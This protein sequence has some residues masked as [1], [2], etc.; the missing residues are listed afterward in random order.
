MAQSKQFNLSSLD[1]QK[2]FK[3]TLL[4]SSPAILS[5]LFVLQG[6]YVNHQSFPNQQEMVFAFGAAYSALLASAI[7]LL[8]KYVSGK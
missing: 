6:A 5:F 1:V 8:K 3:N 2:W 7:D 4:F